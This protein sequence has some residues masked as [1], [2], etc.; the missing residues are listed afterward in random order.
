V[1][2]YYIRHRN[3][4]MLNTANESQLVSKC[5]EAAIERRVCEVSCYQVKPRT[6]PSS[7]LGP[8]F[9]IPNCYQGVRLELCAQNSVGLLPYVTRTLREYGLTVA[10]ADIATQGEKTKNV[11][12]VQDIS[13][14]KVDMSILELMRRELEPLAFQVKNE[15]LQPQRLNSMERESFSFGGLLREIV[16]QLYNSTWGVRDVCFFVHCI[17]VWLEFV[18]AL[19]ICCICEMQTSFSFSVFYQKR[20]LKSYESVNVSSGFHFRTFFSRRRSIFSNLLFFSSFS[21]SL[22]PK[23]II[24]SFFFPS[25]V[26]PFSWHNR[27]CICIF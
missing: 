9:T 23:A 2:E 19:Y 11:F 13:G 24:S 7:S 14:N 3:G 15:L 12:Y 4:Y 26:H 10:R 27:C 1:Q 22:E 25:C 16:S 5:L 8:L 20:N 17:C 18:T 21:L 6:P